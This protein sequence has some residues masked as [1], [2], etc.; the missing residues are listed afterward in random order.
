VVSAGLG[1]THTVITQHRGLA[2]ELRSR[3]HSPISTDDIGIVQASARA[4][5]RSSG[6][7]GRQCP[8]GRPL[9]P[10]VSEGA[11][12]S[13]ANRSETVPRAGSVCAC[14]LRGVLRRPSGRC[15][16]IRRGPQAEARRAAM[17][18]GGVG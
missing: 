13:G 7:E 8:F 10:M 18:G 15:R 4:G 5:D 17:R 9:R 11:A 1:H 2:Q 3:P 6:P 16:R 14:D 12:L